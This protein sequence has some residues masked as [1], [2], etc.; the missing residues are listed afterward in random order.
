MM[1][2]HCSDCR[3]NR[4]QKNSMEIISTW[5]GKDD[6]SKRQS[7]HCV[8]YVSNKNIWVFKNKNAMQ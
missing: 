7:S 3:A 6:S 2:E 8:I 1:D 5:N 4:L